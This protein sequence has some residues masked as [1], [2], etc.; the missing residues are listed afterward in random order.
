[1]A[2][3]AIIGGGLAG[4]CAAHRLSRARH[5]VLVLEAE[6]RLGGQIQTARNAGF[7]AELGAEGYVAR[8]EALPKLARELG[9]ESE[10]VGQIELRS[11]GYRSGQLQVLAPGES[12]S[13][14]GFQVAKSDLGEGIRTLRNGMAEL[15]EA[16]EQKL[17]STV[18]IRLGFRVEHVE[19]R[20]KGF[21]LRAADGTSL[22][23]DRLVI[24]T[25]AH[26]AAPLLGPQIGPAALDLA[27]VTA[28]SSVNV[29][30]AFPRA[31]IA[32]P[33]DATGVVFAEADQLYG[34][35]ACVFASSK[36]AARAPEGYVNLRVFFRPD[37]RELKMLSDAEYK[38][39][40][41]EVLERVVG[42]TGPAEKSWVAR[43]ADALPVFDADSKHIL[44]ALETALKGSGIA[45]AG[46][47]FHGSGIDAA[48][49]SGLSIDQRLFP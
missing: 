17:A 38:E 5:S 20:A 44:Q 45:V 23:A 19:R 2:R 15:I 48:V 8:S 41:R 46:S 25:S 7:V 26:A 9:V 28:H 49:R 47:A 42:P 14:L 27:R 33:L 31:A 10:L 39:R 16:L 30:L 4:L 6:S 13:F 40:A 36:F 35:R 32:H 29:S 37:P 24:A 11:L 18:E 43:W 22:T 34:C 21:T 12:A 3:I 1:M